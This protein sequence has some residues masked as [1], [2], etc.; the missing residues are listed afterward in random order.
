MPSEVIEPPQ[1]DTPVYVPPRVLEAPKPKVNRGDVFRENLVKALKEEQGEAAVPTSPEKLVEVPKEEPKTEV[2]P[3]PEV[4]TETPKSPL[5]VVT[6]DKK[7]EVKVDE[8]EDVLKDFDEKTPDWKRAR[9]VMKTQSREKRE[10]E[11]TIAE[12]KKTPKTDP[13]EITRLAKERD[14][15]KQSLSER[16]EMISAI[17]VR[18]SAEYQSTLKSRD[19]KI[20]KVAS[21]AKA[22][23]ADADALVGALNLPDGT[24]KTQ[25][26]K[27]AMAE[28]D[29]EDKT[30]I[31]L[32]IGEVDGLNE[33]LQ[34]FETNALTKAAELQ[35]KREAALQEQQE[36]SIKTIHSEFGKVTEALPVDIVTL[37]E[38]PE[39]VPG[40]TEWNEAIKNA[41]ENA[42]RIL[43]PG[44]SDFKESA[45]VAVKGAHYDALM[46][47][48]LKDH[49][50]LVDARKRLAEYD[51][52]GPDF[53]GGD[54][55]KTEPKMSAS[56]KYHKAM[57]SIKSS[58]TD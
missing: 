17:D 53:K 2:T 43:S 24:F 46:N 36:A 21:K 40:G 44:G 52:G 29:P 15:L 57:E 38:V 10:L 41:R 50:E 51:S 56:Q 22:Y 6:A 55:P 33:K 12:L 13:E 54:K 11:K 20:G 16:E 3:E 32:L 4:K 1:T 35:A 42:L 39:D 58:P 48:F 45:S 34:D 5:D 47:M 49:S 7:P 30:E 19:T 25:Q 27:A 14:D 18:L 8:P 31:R 23:G 26:I 37:R 9:E 28:V